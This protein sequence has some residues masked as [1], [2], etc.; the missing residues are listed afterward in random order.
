VIKDLPILAV[1]VAAA[2]AV[3]A[4][5]VV[6]A[7]TEVMVALVA[8]EASIRVRAPAPFVTTNHRKSITKIMICCAATCMK[9][10]KSAPGVKRATVPSINASWL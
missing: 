2:T 7:A 10:E 1:G 3:T 9:T 4:A 5:I 6:I 8:A